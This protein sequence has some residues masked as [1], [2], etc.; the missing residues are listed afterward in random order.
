[1][2]NTT[3]EGFTLVETLLVILVLTVIGFTGYYVWDKQSS[4]NNDTKESTTTHKESNSKNAAKS[5]TDEADTW[6]LYETPDKGYA[7]RIADGLKVLKSDVANNG[8]DGTF[9]IIR[10]V[11]PVKGQ[12]VTYAPLPATD[13]GGGFSVNFGVEQVYGVERATVQPSLKTK[14]GIEIKKYKFTQ[15]TEP[16]GIDIA[17]GETEYTYVAQ[18]KGKTVVASYITGD[19]A[20]L[21]TVEKMVKTIQLR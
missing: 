19:S 4:K 11:V 6:T 20:G 16:E 13:G 12:Q 18:S 3:H 10:Q 21:E 2:K 14:D 15:T 1:M 5:S 7:I 8:S 9:L 17:V